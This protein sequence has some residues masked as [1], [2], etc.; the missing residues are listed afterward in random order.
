MLKGKSTIELFDGITGKKKEEH[1]DENLVTNAITNLLDLRNDLLARGVAVHSILERVTPLYPHYL[2]GILLWDSVLDN[3]RELIIPP[4]GIKCVGHAG[5]NYGGPNPLRGCLNENETEVNGNTI[6]MVWDFATDKAEATIRSVSLTSVLGGDRGWMTPWEAGTFLRARINNGNMS[7]AVVPYAPQAPLASL[8]TGWTY[9]GEL[10]RG[11]HTYVG[12]R[13]DNNLSILEQTFTNAESFG[14]CD[15]MGLL[16]SSQPY[17]TEAQFTVESDARF[18]NLN[19]NSIIDRDMNLVHVM[20]TGSRVARI[21]TV[22]LAT[23]TLVSDRTITLSEDVRSDGATLFKGKIYASST[24]RNSICEFNGENGQ[25][26]RSFNTNFQAQTRFYCWNGEYLF[27]QNNPSAGLLMTDGVNHLMTQ[28]GH[29]MISTPSM[30][31]AVSL[32][33]P[34]LT[35][36]SDVHPLGQK[37]ISFITPYMATINNLQTPVVKNN[38]NTMKITYELTQ[39]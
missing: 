32:K 11:V 10:R 14:V 29:D 36:L 7:Q 16:T 3:N 5:G 15:S 33:P 18:L 6:K 26:I 19:T 27:S 38:L 31:N 23:K 13:N 20:L 2:R 28:V 39:D 1:T 12:D 9:M 24:T 37:S 21:R 35:V 4:P 34:L 17:C 25:F 8:A 22:N 30:M